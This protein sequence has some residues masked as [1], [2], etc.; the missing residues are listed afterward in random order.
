MVIPPL[1]QEELVTPLAGCAEAPLGR[2]RGG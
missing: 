2:A 1:N